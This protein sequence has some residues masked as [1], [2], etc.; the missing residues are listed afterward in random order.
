MAAILKFIMHHRTQGKGVEA[1]HL[2]GIKEGLES[3]DHQVSIAS[4]LGI[5]VS[6]TIQEAPSASSTRIMSTFS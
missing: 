3:L 6:H 4:P 1:V 5:E 2:L